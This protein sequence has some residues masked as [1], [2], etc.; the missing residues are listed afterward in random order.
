MEQKI[1]K[2]FFNFEIIAF[3]LGVADSHPLEQ[4]ICDWQSMC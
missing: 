1:E 4:D 2:N 3:E